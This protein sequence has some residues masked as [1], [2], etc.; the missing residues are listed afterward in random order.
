MSPRLLALL[1]RARRHVMTPEEARAQAISFA[2]GNLNAWRDRCTREA[3]E[4]A[5]RRLDAAGDRPGAPKG[6]ENRDF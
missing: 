2:W 4:E 3:F 5:L 1:E 6:P